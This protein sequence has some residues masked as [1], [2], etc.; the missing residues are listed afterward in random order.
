MGSFF[1]LVDTKF[2]LFFQ[3]FSKVEAMIPYS[4]SVSPNILYPARANEF[5]V[6]GN[7]VFLNGAILLLLEIISVIKS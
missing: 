2:F 6:Y 1:L 7:S 4:K 3:V 5:P